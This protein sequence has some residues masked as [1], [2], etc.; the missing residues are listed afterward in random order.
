MKKFIQV[1]KKYNILLIGIITVMCIASLVWVFHNDVTPAAGKSL[2]ESINVEY[3]TVTAVIDDDNSVTQ[4]FKTS[5]NVYGV[6]LKF[7]TE[8]QV[9]R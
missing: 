4:D 5:A 9:T 8:G 6:V 7:A 2:W 1:N 3:D